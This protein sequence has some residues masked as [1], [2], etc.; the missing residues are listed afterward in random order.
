[1]LEQSEQ[2]AEVSQRG[3]SNRVLT[4]CLLVCCRCWIFQE[5][6]QKWTVSCCYVAEG[7]LPAHNWA[8]KTE[9]SRFADPI[10]TGTAPVLVVLLLLL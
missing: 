3:T 2:D 10:S 8:C 6:R 9:A 7:I 4:V 5:Q 1:M